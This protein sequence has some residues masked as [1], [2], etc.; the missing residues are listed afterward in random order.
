MNEATN[1]WL[2]FL[3]LLKVG[4]YCGFLLSVTFAVLVE[5]C[6][7]KI[8]ALGIEQVRGE[9]LASTENRSDASVFDWATS[10]P[11]NSRAA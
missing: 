5:C 4:C 6:G 3:L 9:Q 1:L 8:V 11:R 7:W 10:S 2:L